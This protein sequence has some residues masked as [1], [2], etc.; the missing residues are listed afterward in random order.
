[1]AVLA[2]TILGLMGSADGA[3]ATTAPTPLVLPQSTAFT[4]LGHSCG[5]IQEEAYATGFDASSGY[6]TGVV[7]ASTT[8]S[9]G[10]RG[11]RPSTFASWIN[12][13]WYFTG[14]LVTSSLATSTPTVDP[15]LSVFDQYG[16]QLYNASN[17]AYFVPAATFT[18]LP[19]VTGLSVSAGPSSGG[20]SVG[21]SGYGLTGVTSVTFGGVAATSFTVNGDTTITAVTP[22]HNPGVA[23]VTAANGE[24]S[25]A[26]SAADQ[27]AFV[28][29][30]TI[31]SVTPNIGP[32]AGG[33]SV[34]IKGTGFTN[35]TEVSFGG[36]PIYPTDSSSTSLTVTSPPGE[37]VDTV[38]ITVTTIGGTSAHN[39]AAQFTY[40]RPVS[41]SSVT[42]MVGETITISNCSPKSTKYVSA[43]LASGASVLNWSPNG[44]TTTLSLDPLTSLGQGSCAS[45]HIEYEYS[46][47]VIG[48]TST[49]A[50]VGDE[51]SGLTCV[52]SSGATKVLKGTRFDF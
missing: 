17:D 47:T 26:S 40:R 11:S 45:G 5:G 25:S 46:G 4:Y 35:S 18:P 38:A 6:P 29:R 22:I 42:G 7:Y 44:G 9:S 30:P 19:I 8:C 21:I 14:T 50:T 43:S 1:M 3:G 28:A 23:D 32:L 49:Y 13:T 37:S 24:G 52:A 16:N 41:C 12:A 31:S 51:V 2:A 15:G 36:Y 39:G 33:T 34:R 27:F 20:T 10:G 48:G